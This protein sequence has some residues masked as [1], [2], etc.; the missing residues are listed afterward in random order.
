MSFYKLS[1]IKEFLNQQRY[2]GRG[3]VI[4]KTKSNKAVIAYFITGRSEN[5]KNRIFVKEGEDIKIKLFDNDKVEDTS[6]ILYSPIRFINNNVIVTNGDQT[7]T[8][9]DFIKNGK[10]FEQ[11]LKTRQFEPDSPNFTPRISGIVNFFEKNFDYQMSILKSGDEVGT[12][13]NRYTYSYEALSG[14]G[15]FIHTYNSDGNPIP[16]FTGEPKRIEI[17]DDIELFTNLIW[18]NLDDEYKISL[19]VIYIDN[20][21][22]NVDTKIIN[23]N[24]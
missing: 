12:I 23:I 19:S 11:A 17:I 7:D 21:T 4:G 14:V 6:L 20:E 16:T 10:T 8:I 13:C 5:S 24:N 3:I 22:K 9:Y 1:S 18:E 2:L 15:H